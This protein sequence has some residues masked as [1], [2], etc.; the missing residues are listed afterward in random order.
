[1]KSRHDHL[2]PQKAKKMLEEGTANGQAL[3]ARQRRYFGLIAS[4]KTPRKK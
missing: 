2:S 3:T 1:M 4:G